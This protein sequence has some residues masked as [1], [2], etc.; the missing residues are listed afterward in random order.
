[1]KA[2]IKQSVKWILIGRQGQFVVSLFFHLLIM[3]ILSPEV[4]GVFALAESSLGFIAMFI[5]FGFAHCVIQ[6][7]EVKN[8]ERN[9]LGITILQA[10][11]Y[12]VLTVPGALIVSRVYGEQISRIY[13]LL[14]AGHILTFFSLIF[15]FVIERNLDFKTTEIVHFLARTAGILATLGLALAGAGVY[16]LVA[17]MYVRVLLETVIFFKCCRW[18]YGVGWEK[19]VL[20]VV[21]V[22]GSKKFVVRICATMMQSLDKLILGLMVPVAFV[23]AYERGL[24]IVSSAVGLVREINARF[25]FSLINR[26]KSDLRRLDSLIN[27]GIFLNL[28]LGSFFAL[29]AIFFLRDLIVL[30]LGAR[31]VPTARALPFFSLYLVVIVPAV[32]IQQVFFAVKDPLHVAWGRLME[33]AIFLLIS[34]GIYRLAGAEDGPSPIYLMALNLGFSQLAGVGYLLAILLRL[35]QLQPALLV[36]PLVLAVS[37]G[38]VGWGLLVY[39]GLPSPA[40][41]VVVCLIYLGLLWTACRPELL[42]LKR[43]WWN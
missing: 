31:W 43:Y 38:L 39:S 34:L 18:E 8:I 25:A 3:R 22:Y 10:A 28:A 23:G 15:Q 30:V 2:K 1:M 5:S 40:V 21:L 37:A 20:R 16:S 9:V 4:F 17:G 35:Q 13:L 42:W 32:F 14:I 12:A 41:S 29:A 36:K 6:F 7:Q 19:E 27:L 33:I 26:L 11:A 24:M